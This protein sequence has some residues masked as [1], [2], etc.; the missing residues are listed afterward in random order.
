MEEFP[1]LFKR[2]IRLECGPG[3]H[4]LI[5]RICDAI[6]PLVIANGLHDFEVVQIKEKFGALRFYVHNGNDEIYTIIDR[7]ES[8]SIYICEECGAVENV[9][10]RNS[11]W[12]RHLC[13]KC[14]K[15]PKEVIRLDEDPLC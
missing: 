3:W 13:D 7:H 12:I 5:R 11:G 6:K 15:Q 4:Q 9:H 14:F 1:E 2:S 10:C 8:D